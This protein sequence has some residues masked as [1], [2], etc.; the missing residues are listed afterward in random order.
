VSFL[1]VSSQT[2]DAGFEAEAKRLATSIRVLVRDR[3]NSKSLIRELGLKESMT[4]EDMTIRQEVLLPGLTAW[5]PGTIVLDSRITV[6]PM[7]FGPHAGTEFLAPLDE[8][9]PASSPYARPAGE[10]AWSAPQGTH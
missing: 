10:Y 3:R 2:F 1:R 8:V 9:A 7:K 4:F 6:T 5:P